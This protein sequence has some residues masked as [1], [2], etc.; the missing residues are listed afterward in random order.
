MMVYPVP[1]GEKITIKLHDNMPLEGSRLFIYDLHGRL[2]FDQAVLQHSFELSLSGLNR[3]I[4]VVKFVGSN[5]TRVGK[6][7]RD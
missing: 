7:I 1:A 4:Y 5:E 2:V 6:M 3:G